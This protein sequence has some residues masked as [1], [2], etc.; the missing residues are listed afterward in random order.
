MRGDA[1]RFTALGAASPS[2]VLKSQPFR[3]KVWHVHLSA[4]VLSARRRSLPAVL[5]RRLDVEAPLAALGAQRSPFRCA[6]QLLANSWVL[7]R[8]LGLKLRQRGKSE[9][10]LAETTGRKG[11]TRHKGRQF[12]L[13]KGTRD[14]PWPGFSGANFK[15]GARFLTQ[16]CR[17]APSTTEKRTPGEKVSRRRIQKQSSACKK[18]SHRSRASSSPTETRMSPS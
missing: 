3:G 4:A 13:P 1:C 12:I 14:R 9:K 5:F 16:T 18:S 7:A 2:A 17:R 8:R 6:V 15:K 10:K 11:K